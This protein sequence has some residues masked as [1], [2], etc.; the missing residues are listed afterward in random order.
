[1]V[2]HI[3]RRLLEGCF[4]LAL[5]FSWQ[6]CQVVDL[7]GLSGYDIFNKAVFL[8]GLIKRLTVWKKRELV[9]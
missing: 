9:E 4:E 5:F 1:M 7:P 6:G 3:F 2:L 8:A